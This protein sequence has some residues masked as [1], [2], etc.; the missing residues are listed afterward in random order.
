MKIRLNRVIAV[1]LL[2]LLGISVFATNSTDAVAQ[3]KTAPDA[4]AF[5]PQSDGVLVV[6]VNRLINETLPRVFAASTDKLTHIN[7]DIDSFKTKTGIDPRAFDRVVVGVRFTNP[8]PNVTKVESVAIAQGKFDVK[9]LAAAGREAAKGNVREEKYRNT[10]IMTF[11]IND[12]MKLFGLWNVKVK[13]L[14]VAVLNPTTLAIGDPENVRR[15][16]DSNRTRRRY[17]VELIALATR[18]PQAVIGF[19][20]NMPRNLMSNFELATDAIAQDVNSIRQMYGSIGNTATDVSLAVVARTDTPASAKNLGETV[21]GLKQLA[22]FLIMRLK[23]DQQALAQGAMGNLK[24]TTRGNELE[25]RTQVSSAN[26]AA[27][28]K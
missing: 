25:I 28:V 1:A 27:L 24:I 9:S 10:T 17:N 4:F 5:L 18:D 15:V 23:D 12:Q 21:T 6:D 14:S 16:I 22:G 19:G 3:K 7:A 11:G 26:L 13:E 2:A 20:S 8:T